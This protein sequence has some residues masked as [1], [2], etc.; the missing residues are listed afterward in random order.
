M[1]ASLDLSNK[2][3]L[4]SGGSMGIGYAAAEVC[5][6]AGAR[7]VLC[8]RT[9]KPLEEAVAR[10][11]GADEDRVAA[12]VADVTV[13]SQVDKALDLV[14]SRFGAVNGVIHCA[15]VYGPIGPIT[16]A[17]PEAWLDAIRINLFGS[18]LVA[19]QACTRFKKIGGG[20]LSLFS[21]G[22]AATPF[23]NY[24]AYACSKI[25]VVRL[26]ETLAREMAPHN[27]EVNCV[28]PGFVATR[29]HE[30]TLAA[31]EELAGKDF[32]AYTKDQMEKGGVPAAMGATAAAFLISDAAKGITGRFVAAPYDDWRDWP[33]HLE[34][35]E[36]SD[37]FT[38]RRVLPKD[39]GHD[40]Q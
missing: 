16:T 24:T 8:A 15:G 4:I 31:G 14:D 18:F 9:R 30:Q 37:I 21:G 40:W 12:A 27:I 34:A 11:G 2:N 20:R 1:S 13:E 38:L 5:L 33:R 3:I 7:I 32:L 28:A 39:R 22:G 26:T 25:G 19:R 35:F 23:P 10:L 36:G 29:L 6:K 17:D